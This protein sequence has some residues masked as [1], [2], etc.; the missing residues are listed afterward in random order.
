[1]EKKSTL[2]QAFKN[3][4][5]LPA[6]PV[7]RPFVRHL[8]P[9]PSP[10]MIFHF[11]PPCSQI[12]LSVI[13]PTLDAKRDGHFE[14]L[15]QQV[16]SQTLPDLEVIIVRGDS[17]QGRAINVG[18]SLARGEYLLT[19]D[20]DSALPDQ[21][22]IAK[23][24]RVM[25]EH[26][27]IGMAGGINV[28]P[29]DASWFVRRTMKE[30]P[31]RSTPPVS[32]IT[33]SDLAEHPL[34]IMR[35][36]YFEKVGGENELLPR[37]LDPYLRNEFRKAGYRVVVVP[38]APYSHLPPNSL[39]TLL[40]QFYRNGGHSSYVNRYFPQWAIETPDK[41]GT[42]RSH[43][44]LPLRVFRFPLRILS[45]LIALKP[46]WFI[47]LL[48]YAAGFAADQMASSLCPKK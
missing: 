21:Q 32:E 14:R 27:E 18:A 38:N 34:L 42:F 11:V 25:E 8:H 37:G 9:E 24:M 31:R 28:I 22:V 3:A 16:E 39:Q 15:L 23:L 5:W 46:I 47:C 26:P 35:K 48:S 36:E 4:Q 45:A 13:I 7:E 43:H 10:A 20:D 41:H 44:A 29:P 12:L 6:A 17:R 30:I 40:K 2:F 33:D 1:M 19:L